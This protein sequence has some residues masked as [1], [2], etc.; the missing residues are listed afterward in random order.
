M[1]GDRNKDRL[2]AKVESGLNGCFA[3][4]ETGDIITF[5]HSIAVELIQRGVIFQRNGKWRIKDEDAN[6]IEEKYP[7]LG[8]CDFCSARPIAYDIEADDFEDESRHAS[9]GG[10]AACAECGQLIEARDRGGLYK[11]ATK[12]QGLDAGDPVA[13]AIRLQLAKFYESF[14]AHFKSIKPYK[15]RPFGH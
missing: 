1:F 4:T 8:V 7:Y 14:W 5:H 15:Q 11:R 12:A 10:W 3:E 6:I 13:R 2:L 9:V